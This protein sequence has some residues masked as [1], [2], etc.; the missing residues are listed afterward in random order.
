MPRLARLKA[1]KA[2]AVPSVKGGPQPRQASPPFGFSTLITSAPSS[3]RII[4][5]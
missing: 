1:W 4:P 5:A 2:V 3:P